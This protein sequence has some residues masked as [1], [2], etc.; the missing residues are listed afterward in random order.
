MTGLGEWGVGG[1]GGGWGVKG[2]AEDGRECL[3]KQ[4]KRAF[5]IIDR[6]YRLSN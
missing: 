4:G 2:N 3:I 5:V 1:R 6:I